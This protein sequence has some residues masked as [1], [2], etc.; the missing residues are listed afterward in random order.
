MSRVL[1]TGSLGNVGREVVRACA[2]RGLAVRVAGRSEQAL[3]QSFPG[4]EPVRFDFEA[5]ETWPAALAGCDF[6]FL[7][8]PPALANMTV[9]LNPFIDAAYAAGV[10]HIVFVSVAG[11]DQMK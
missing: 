1:V 9:T 11:A 4:L 5:P 10:R 6:V 3:R 8:R 2:E 7:L